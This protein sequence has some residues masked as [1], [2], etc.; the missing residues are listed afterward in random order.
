MFKRFIIQ[1]LDIH[2][3]AHMKSRHMTIKMMLRMG[4]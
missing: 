4:V 3:K 1:W 2:G